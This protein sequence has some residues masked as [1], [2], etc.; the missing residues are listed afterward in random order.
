MN[1]ETKSEKKEVEGLNCF[2]VTWSLNLLGDHTIKN[3]KL[4][5]L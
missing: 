4:I 1:K 2:Q 3:N 5:Y